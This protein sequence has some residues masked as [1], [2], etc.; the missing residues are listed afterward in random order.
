[1]IEPAH[2]VLDGLDLRDVR[3]RWAA[4]YDDLDA[5]RA[6]RGDLAVGRVAAAVLGDDDFD[7]MRRHQ[8]AI[9]FF[10]ERPAS[11]DVLHARQ[12]E[13]RVDGI[14]AA[15]QIVMLRRVQERDEILPAERKKDAPRLIAQRLDRP[16]QRV[17]LIPQ[18]ARDSLPRRTSQRQ[19]FGARLCDR[20][21]G[22]GGN[23][24]GIRM[25]RID[26]D[27]DALVGQIFGKAFRAAEAADPH[28]NGLRRGR[29]GAAGERQRYADIVAPSELS[30]QLPRFRRAAEYEYAP[31]AA[32]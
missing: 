9:V 12:S 7:M 21:R 30:R 10:G 2:G 3:Q 23:G 6:G 25:C 19:Q 31:H 14:D 16:G 4:Q 29:S 15:D 26:Q 11:G 24:R 1:M 17:D 18:I 28:G 32:R 13:R 20:Q 8:R 27:I 22:V 5:E